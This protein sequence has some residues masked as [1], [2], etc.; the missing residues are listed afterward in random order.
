MKFLYLVLIIIIG[1]FLGSIP[2]GLLIAKKVKGIDIRQFGSGNVGATNVTRL[3]GKEWGITVFFLDACK[4][5]LAAKI[6]LW[7]AG[8]AGGLAGGVAAVSGH[9]LPVWL[10]FKGGKGIATGFGF[11]MAVMPV[12]GLVGILTWGIVTYASGYVSLGSICAASVVLIFAVFYETYFWYKLLLLIFVSLIIY[13]HRTN[14]QRLLN[15]TES[16]ID[17]K[18]FFHI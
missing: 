3:L 15:K 2:F 17:R 9:M 11:L 4:G 16:K 5:F 7:L 1:Y 13:K 6:G 8:P 18:K 14:I 10:Q 12:T